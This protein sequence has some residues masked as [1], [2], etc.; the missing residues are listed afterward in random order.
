MKIHCLVVGQLQTN[1]Y[2]AVCP[3]TDQC[4]VIDPGDSAEFISEKILNP[5]I[6]PKFIILTHGHFDHIMAAEELRLNFKAPILVH[7]DDLF[8]VK[9]VQESASHWLAG[10]Q[11]FLPAKQVKFIKEGDQIKFGKEKLAVI[12]T[13]GHTPGSIS[14]FNQ[15]EKVIFCG[16]LVFKNGVGRTDFSYGSSEN[17]QD[18]LKKIF[19]LPPETVIYPGH[20]EEFALKRN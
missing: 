9:Q 3:K 18:S 12:H 8:L 13:P 6:K 19:S 16:D 7:R 14:L 4:V 1:C 5:G 15:K 10:K 2:L 17:L 11:E 20:G